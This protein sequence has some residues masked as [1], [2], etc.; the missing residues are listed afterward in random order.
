MAH[1]P[2]AIYLHIDHNINEVYKRSSITNGS[3]YVN[4]G[5]WKG[6]SRFQK[7]AKPRRQLKIQSSQ[8]YQNC[9]NQ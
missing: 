4:G 3:R 6:D 7:R 9:V 1:I 8:S 5:K 2:S